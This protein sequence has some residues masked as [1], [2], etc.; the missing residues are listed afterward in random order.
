[1]IPRYRMVVSYEK[2]ELYEIIHPTK[3]NM[4]KLD[5]CIIAEQEGMMLGDPMDFLDRQIRGQIEED[6][7]YDVMMILKKKSE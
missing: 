2:K 7:E 1:M 3:G 6:S 5:G 4:V